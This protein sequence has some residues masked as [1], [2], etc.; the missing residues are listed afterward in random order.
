MRTSKRNKKALEVAAAIAAA[1]K[2]VSDRERL[3]KKKKTRF[4]LS[5]TPETANP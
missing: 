4:S 2:Q 5:G 3:V 1:M